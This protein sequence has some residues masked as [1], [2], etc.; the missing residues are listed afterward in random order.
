MDYDC[1]IEYQPGKANVVA[2]ILSRKKR[3]DLIK[4]AK[5]LARE[6]EKLGIEVRVP[7]GNKE[8]LYKITFQPELMEGIKK[9][10]EKVMNPGLDSSTGKEICN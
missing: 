1:S 7:E 6:L 4:I 9:C 3:L 8:Q 5:E 2:D 10:Q